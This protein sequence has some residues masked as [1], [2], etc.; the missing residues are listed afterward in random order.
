MEACQA[1]IL[2]MRKEQSEVLQINQ[3]L[4]DKLTRS[5]YQLLGQRLIEISKRKQQKNINQAFGQLRSLVA[6]K[7]K[8][9]VV[10]KELER[11]QLEGRL[12]QQRSELEAEFTKHLQSIARD[13]DKLRSQVAL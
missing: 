4:C 3:Q 10:K 1:V 8:F 9:D 7:E 2:D 13:N 5:R 12:N 11:E 6:P